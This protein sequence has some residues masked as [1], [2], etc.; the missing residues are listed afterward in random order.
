MSES[1][2]S[3]TALE[4]EHRIIAI[5]VENISKL[6]LVAAEPGDFMSIKWRACFEAL[7]ELQAEFREVDPLMLAD[8]L[9]GA[10][11]GRGN[12]LNVGY[13]D[14]TSIDASPVLIER[15]SDIV[16]EEASKRR[17]RMGLHSALNAIEGGSTASDALSMAAKAIAEAT[18]GQPAEAKPIGQILKERALDMIDR[19]E[20]KAKGELCVTGIPTGIPKLDSMGLLRPKIVTL[21]AGRPAMGKSAITLALANGVNRGGAGVHVFQLEDGEEAYGDRALSLASGVNTMRMSALELTRSDMASMLDAVNRGMK[22]TGWLVDSRSGISA[23]EIVRCVRREAL[24][25]KTRVV[26]VDYV[27]LLRGLKGQ[28]RKDRIAEAMDTF[29]DAADADNMAYLV[30]SQ[31]NRDC[32]KRDDKRP[33]PNDLAEC[34]E[35]EQRSKC[36]MMLY[37]PA[38]YGDK[39]AQGQ[40]QGRQRPGQRTGEQIPGSVMEILLRK[41]SQGETGTVMATWEPERMRITGDKE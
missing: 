20:R 38:V 9:V 29:A 26:V 18:M 24:T 30:G 32:E 8:K 14:L 36:I 17:L 35:L 22:R 25:N 33:V 23:E 1:F 13:S 31:L 2:T 16:Q 4:A 40:Y 15:Y 28:S 3:S 5:C 11:D 41:N 6:D 37:R 21:V 19:A 27:Q 12:K 39:Y 7:R 34:G 10:T